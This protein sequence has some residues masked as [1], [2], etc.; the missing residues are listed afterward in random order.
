MKKKNEKLTAE[1]IEDEKLLAKKEKLLKEIAAHSAVCQH[2]GCP[3]HEHCMLWLAGRYVNRNMRIIRSVNTQFSLVANGNCDLYCDDKPVRMKVGM[4]R[5]FY[6]MP[7]HTKRAI[8]NRL[9]ALNCR[10]TFYKYYSGYR[11]ISPTLLRQ[12]E[13]ICREEGWTAPLEFDRETVDYVLP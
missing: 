13:A 6:E 1:P 10:T 7:D 11:P 2:D 8:R 12:I 3:R 9:I 4:K 5:L